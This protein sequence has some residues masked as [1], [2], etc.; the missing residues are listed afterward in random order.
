MASPLLPERTFVLTLPDHAGALRVQAI[1]GLRQSRSLNVTGRWAAEGSKPVPLL[2]WGD[3]DSAST[4]AGV[5]AEARGRTV[6]VTD[7]ALDHPAHFKMFSEAHRPALLGYLPY[8]EAAARKL[9]AERVKTMLYAIAVLTFAE[10]ETKEAKE[11][12]A[13]QAARE[14][15]RHYGGGSVLSAAQYLAGTRARDVLARVLDGELAC[16]AEAATED[17]V[18]ACVMARML[19]HELSR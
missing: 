18:K 8:T 5:A 16:D 3:A 10:A 12:A 9:E 11:V 2:T 14:L 6:I 1:H 4:A 19:M 17:L 13:K 7:V 15:A